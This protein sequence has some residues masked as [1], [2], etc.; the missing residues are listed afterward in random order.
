M[1]ANGLDDKSFGKLVGRNR[2]QIYRIRNGQSRPS[3]ELKAL[4]AKKT[5]GAVPVE[6]W[7]PALPKARAA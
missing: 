1:I 5:K 6:S 2:S 7:F 3:D 4:I